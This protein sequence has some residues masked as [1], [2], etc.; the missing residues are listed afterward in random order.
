MMRCLAH[1]AG[2]ED[3]AERVVD[4][5]GAGVVELVALE[6]DLRAAEPLGQALGEVERRGA[7]DVVLPEVVHLGPE[8]RVGLGL[9]VLGLEV[10]DERHQRLGDEAAAEVAETAA[11]VGAGAEGVG[12]LVHGAPLGVPEC[13][14]GAFRTRN[15]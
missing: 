11:L 2:E 14:T 13:E 6:V 1:A 5:V 10:E 15:Y 7:A 12:L 3:L 8:G 4:L 9:L